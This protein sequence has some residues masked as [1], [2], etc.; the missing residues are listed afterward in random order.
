[1]TPRRQEQTKSWRNP[2]NRLAACELTGRCLAIFFGFAGEVT[3]SQR[4]DDQASVHVT[5]L[6]VNEFPPSVV[7]SRPLGPS[8]VSLLSSIA[9]K[10]QWSTCAFFLSPIGRLCKTPSTNIS[11]IGYI[12]MSLLGGQSSYVLKYTNRT[13]SSLLLLVDFARCPK[14]GL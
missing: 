11:I 6:D 1:M 3:L 7:V 4:L 14:R 8:L 5:I 12:M 9:S 10:G 2:S 13:L